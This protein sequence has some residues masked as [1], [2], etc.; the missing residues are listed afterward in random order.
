MITGKP[1]LDDCRPP[2]SQLFGEC[3]QR[4]DSFV[5]CEPGP[6]PTRWGY[7][8]EEH[9]HDVNLAL[10]QKTVDLTCE[11]ICVVWKAVHGK[12][13]PSWLPVRDSN[14]RFPRV[15]VVLRSVKSEAVL[16]GSTTK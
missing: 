2:L 7:V 5:H 9:F 15:Q 11:A 4:R 1:K 8:K 16:T 3:K 12:D 13:K 6:A 14:G 10:V